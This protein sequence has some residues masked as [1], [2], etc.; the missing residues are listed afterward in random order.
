[1]S[2]ELIIHA[3]ERQV[4][5]FTV[6]RLLPFGL[7]RMVGPFIFVDEMGP[8]AISPHTEGDVLPHP[9]IGLSTVTYLFSGAMLHRDSSGSVQEIHPGDV[10]WMTAGS[11]IVHSERFPESVKKNG[12]L[13]HGLQ[14]WVALPKDKEDTAPTFEH[15]PKSILPTWESGSISWNLILGNAFGKVAPVHV[16]SPLFYCHCV[17]LE[18]T[19]LHLTAEF[20]DS[21]TL[22]RA[23]YVVEGSIETEGQ[24]I[25]K[26]TMV[27]FK[28]NEPISLTLQNGT[29]GMWLGGET[30][31]EKRF[32][33][34]N[35]VSSDE[36]KIEA[37]KARWKAQ[38]FPKIEGETEFIPLP[39]K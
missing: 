4:G 39:E 14:T 7:K 31:P 5:N 17:A 28:P 2:I 24:I 37:G 36:A 34:W 8:H 33:W 10:N 26:G 29:R 38:A 30:F 35:F 18:T 16:Y 1:M 11:G 27:S 15:V 25:S 20:G 13:L 3:R 21:P 32:I 23:F 12:T 9:H 6:K 22:E 19:T